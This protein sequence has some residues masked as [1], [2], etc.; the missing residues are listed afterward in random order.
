VVQSDPADA[1]ALVL[2]GTTHPR[3]D[4][5]SSL[6]IPVTKVYAS[7]D[8]VAPPHRVLANKRLLP[9]HAK[10]VEIKGGNH[11]QFGHYG[12]QFLDGTATITRVAQQ[13][14]TRAALLQS[15]GSRE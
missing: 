8:G 9:E 2:I 1:S 10:W 12:H 5:L 6:R 4:D 11:S 7:N 3:E 13:E 14:I 15:L